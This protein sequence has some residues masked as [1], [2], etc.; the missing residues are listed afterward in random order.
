VTGSGLLEAY[1]EFP[2]AVQPRLRPLDD[3]TPGAPVGVPAAGRGLRP[4][5]RDVRPVPPGPHGV[6]RRLAGVPFIPAEV[7]ARRLRGRAGDHDAVQRGHEEHHVMALGPAHD[8]GQRDSIPVDEEAA[9]GPFFS[10]DPS[11]S[12]RRLRA[13]GGL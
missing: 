8:E 11:G 3:P 9:L 5:L 2:E 13:R 1:Q 4:P 12:A 7:L 10:P 6:V